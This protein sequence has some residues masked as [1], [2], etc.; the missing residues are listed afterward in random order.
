[1][2]SVDSDPIVKKVAE[3]DLHLHTYWESWNGGSCIVE[4]SLY[5][6]VRDTWKVLWNRSMKKWRD[7]NFTDAAVKREF[8]KRFN[9]IYKKLKR[10]ERIHQRRHIRTSK[11]GRKFVAGRKL[12]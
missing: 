8:G 3:K 11:K 12:R 7:G 2:P 9:R 10:R 6:P 5:D 1:M 4:I